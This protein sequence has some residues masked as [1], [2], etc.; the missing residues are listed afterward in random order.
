MYSCVLIA[1]ILWLT[2]C[3]LRGQRPSCL[4]TLVY[5]DN[6][7]LYSTS[8]ECNDGDILAFADVDVDVPDD[9]EMSMMM[10]MRMK[11]MK[12]MKM[13]MLKMVKMMM[14]LMTTLNHKNNW[15]MPVP[16]LVITTSNISIRRRLASS[17]WRNQPNRH[18]SYS[19]LLEFSDLCFVSQLYSTYICGISTRWALDSVVKW[20]E[21]TPTSRV[22]GNT[23]I[24]NLGSFSSKPC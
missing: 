14:I 16:V 2:F 8:D 6:T 3:L 12:M 4:C 18:L 10:I 23:Y 24:F 21:I 17:I 7:S 1:S 20:S 19:V 9:E 5:V 15:P 11:M 13:M 22:T